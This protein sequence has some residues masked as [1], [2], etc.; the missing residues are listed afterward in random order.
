M[1][2]N[3]TAYCFV[4]LDIVVY[5]HNLRAYCCISALLE[6][7]VPA[8]HLIFVEPFPPPHTV[9][10]IPPHAVSCFNDSDVDAKVQ[11]TLFDLGVTVY[12]GYYFLEWTHNKAIE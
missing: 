2:Q 8:D 12:S 9:S 7:G 1:A 5:G 4:F 10:S 11:A 6:Y 3:N